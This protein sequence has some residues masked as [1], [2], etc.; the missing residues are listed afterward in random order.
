MKRWL[1]ISVAI[2]FIALLGMLWYMISTKMYTFQ[3]VPIK[4]IEYNNANKNSTLVYQLVYKS[5]S[6]DT[7]TFLNSPQLIKDFK[8]KRVTTL[9]IGGT[10]YLLTNAAHVTGEDNMTLTLKSACA[11]TSSSAN[12]QIPTAFASSGTCATIAWTSNTALLVLG[13]F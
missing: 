6:G 12:T 1:A 3:D 13:Y 8:A 7:W 9:L 5:N 11:N 4:T 10:L 2:G